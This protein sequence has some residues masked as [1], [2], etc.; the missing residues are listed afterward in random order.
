MDDQWRR[1]TKVTKCLTRKY[2]IYYF[3]YPPRTPCG[4]VKSGDAVGIFR[5][6]L[7]VGF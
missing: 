5:G 2:E 6:P 3:T 7:E 1:K 4:E